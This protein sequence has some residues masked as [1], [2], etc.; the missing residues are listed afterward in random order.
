MAGVDRVN[1]NCSP[2]RAGTI[3]GGSRG[4]EV[5]AEP[6]REQPDGPP[7]RDINPPE[8]G[9]Y[10]R[11]LDCGGVQIKA[12]GEVC[13]EAMREAALR[14][15]RLLS[16]I[17]VVRRNLVAQEAEVHIIGKDQA[18]SDLP[19][20]RHMKG[21]HITDRV[22]PDGSPMLFD[23]RSRGQ[24]GI[25]SSC[26]E[27]N[28]LQLPCDRY[29]DHRDICSH[30]FAHGIQMH[31]MSPNV[32]EMWLEQY[33]KA[34]G[35][36][37][38]PSYA[39]TN[40]HEYFAEITMWYIGSR[41]DYGRISPEPE[42]GPDWLR[43]YDP[44]GYELADAFYCGRLPVKPLPIGALARVPEA[45]TR[46]RGASG[47]ATTIRFDNRTGNQC[48]VRCLE[49]DGSEPAPQVVPPH[50]PL[51]VPALAGQAWAVF[52]DDGCDGG[53]YVATEDPGLVVIREKGLI[54]AGETPNA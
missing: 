4:Q 38:W 20:W 27:E 21:R 29:A 7:I 2:A 11:L 23:E 36:G 19:E 34:K 13:D 47:R 33:R 32:Q 24:G 35:Q 40:E 44:G 42:P 1:G 54:R 51:V 9:F 30:E 18:T 3:D 5:L 12:P 26:G 53:C 6:S 45:P 22:K 25:V 41:G 16:A 49:G 46:R 8:C 50:R 17:P 52:T 28:L 43:W 48:S 31:G 37:L 39:G 14:I 15:G 10:A